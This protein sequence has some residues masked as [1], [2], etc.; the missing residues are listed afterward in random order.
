MPKRKKNAR[1]N[2]KY[3][4]PLAIA[5]V[6]GIAILASIWFARSLP[7]YSADGA[8]GD[9]FGHVH[10]LGVDPASGDLYA[11]THYGL[12]R[13]NA[14]GEVSKLGPDRDYMGFAIKGPGHFL[15]SGH[16]GIGDDGPSNLGLTESRDGGETWQAMSLAGQ[17]DFHILEVS[18]ERI[19]GYDAGKVKRTE[20]GLAWSTGATLA[21]TDL[22][23][24]SV[25]SNRL[26]A[27][28]PAGIA[29]SDDAGQTFTPLND[30]PVAVLVSWSRPDELV[31]VLANGE[32]IAS[33]DE[34][35]TWEHRGSI[36]GLP[37]AITTTGSSV[38]VATDRSI[39][40]S[41]DGGRTF[42]T[43]VRTSG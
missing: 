39:E 34:A 2:S 19:Y 21:V 8:G 30:S 37:Q 9:D 13:V 3:I 11:G 23:V 16:P 40:V 29:F 32:V 43:L 14:S 4:F 35:K 42:K 36:V 33:S 26:I 41:S 20:N 38:Y 28:T 24:S 10:G 5:V 31:G 25:D 27:S 7:D 1:R 18:T 6:V 15:A 12:H 22:A 17:A